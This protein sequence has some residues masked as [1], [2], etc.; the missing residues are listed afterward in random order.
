M[1]VELKK[2][3]YADLVAECQERD[4]RASTYL[5]QVCCCGFMSLS[6]KHFLGNIGFTSARV[7]K[8]LKDLPEEAEKR[9]FW[10]GE[11]ERKELGEWRSHV[12]QPSDYLIPCPGVKGLKHQ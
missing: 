8:V 12:M 7:K 6:S 1:L 5:V 11:E 10:R 9:S 2:M 3:R 4:W